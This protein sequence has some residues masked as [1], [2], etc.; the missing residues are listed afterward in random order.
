MAAIFEKHIALSGGSGVSGGNISTTSSTYVEPSSPRH[1]RIDT[2]Q[3]NGATYYF[4]G[5]FKTSAATGYMSLYTVG[6]SQ[7]SGSEVT[8][9][10]TS[11]VRVRSGSISPTTGDHMDRFKNDGTNTTTKNNARVIVVQNAASITNTETQIELLNYTPGFTTTSGS[12]VDV[13][14]SATGRFLY[15]SA[16]WDGTVNIYYEATFS[17]NA[18]TAFSQLATD[19]GSA[20]SGS[21]VTTTSTTAVRVRSGA[22]TL[23][24]ATA[25]K[26][27]FKNDGTNTTTIYAGQVI[28][29][30]SGS[31]TKT[32]AY[33]QVRQGNEETNSTSYVDNSHMLYFDPANWSVVSKDFYHEGNIYHT[34]TTGYLDL[35]ALTDAAVVTN[36][37]ISTN[38]TSAITRVRS[39]ALTMPASA[40][41]ISA[42]AKVSG[43]GTLNNGLDFT[44]VVLTWTN[45]IERTYSEIVTITD[46]ILKSTSRTLSEIVTIVDVLTAIK[47]FEKTL[48]ET[49]V[50]V[51]TLLKSTSRTF[52]ETVTIVESFLKTIGKNFTETITLVQVFATTVIFAFRPI[53]KA[54]LNLKSKLSALNFKPKS[55]SKSP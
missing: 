11:Y 35:Y 32:E 43:T 29:Q 2:A 30:Q 46:S 17:T 44:I 21:E 54:A 27:Q 48:N 18:A 51:D 1:R 52:S 9:T 53:L 25:Y 45:I 15:T 10:S 12:Y 47:I 26:P 39:S 34:A 36:S 24:N 8:T 28:V 20:V 7:V 38:T 50:I 3:F 16:N 33:L 40:Q 41:N 23:T 14:G 31:P 55:S 22:I 5:V 6:G 42:R 49:I 19:A 4:E 13:S 37:E